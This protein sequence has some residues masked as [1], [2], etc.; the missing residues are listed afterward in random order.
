MRKWILAVAGLIAF[1][2]SGAAAQTFP[3]RNI[4]MVIPFAAG[5]PTDTIGRLVA[6]AMS[7]TLGQTVIVENVVGAGG[8]RGSVQVA[9]ANPDGYTL[10]LH[11]VGMSTAP[12][13]YRKLPF[14]SLT[15]FETIGLV[16]NAPMS[17]IARPDFPAKDFSE[18]LAFIRENKDKVSY[19]NAG[20]GSASHL[21]GML[22]MSA[23][24]VQMT[25]IP[26]NGT[27]PAMTDLLGGQTDIMSTRPPTPRA[28]KN[29]R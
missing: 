25:T 4:T 8:T 26:Y 7:K 13:L 11:H 29:G 17:L 20:I 12:T 5:G 19:A 2:L 23:I 16:T 28:I 24:G 6:E 1:G 18:V 21:C 22:L 10:L 27:G 3:G 9:K 15:D 14:N